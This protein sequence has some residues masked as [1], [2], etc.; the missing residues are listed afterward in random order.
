MTL[1]SELVRMWRDEAS[2]NIERIDSARGLQ[3]GREHLNAL[4]R[5]REARILTLC[6]ELLDTR[7][8]FKAPDV[9]SVAFMVSRDRPTTDPS[10]DTEVL[11]E[12][13]ERVLRDLLPDLMIRRLDED[14]EAWL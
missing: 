5:P 11:A 2:E 12:R 14:G 4:L 10:G 9:I 13:V 1:A 6:E 3:P 7:V 8:P